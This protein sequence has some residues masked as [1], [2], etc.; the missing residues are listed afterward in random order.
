[1]LA[2]LEHQYGKRY[3]INPFVSTGALTSAPM[4]LTTPIGTPPFPLE[5]RSDD[6]LLQD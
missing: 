4:L 6:S 1:M 3:Q 2:T 5:Q